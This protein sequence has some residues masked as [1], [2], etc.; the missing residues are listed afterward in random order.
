MNHRN[1]LSRRIASAVFLSSAFCLTSPAMAGDGED[2]A[3]EPVS[4]EA[5]YKSDVVGV[6]DGGVAHGVRWLD[7][8]NVTATLDLD[9][10]AGWN[11]ATVFVNVLNNLGGRPNDL[12][13]SI[14]GINNIE[15]ADTRLK[16]YEAWIEQTL[17]K[18]VS[19][20]AG[21]YDLNSEFYQND[22]S[23]LLISPPFGIGSELSATGPNGPS[24]FP[25]TALAARVNA[26]FGD[27]Y[28]R[29]AVVNA[30]AGTLGDEHGVALFGHDGALLIGELGWS[31]NGKVSV[32]FWRYTKDQPLIDAPDITVG[33]TDHRA[34]GIYFSAE[35]ALYAK[36]GGATVSGFLRG[37]VSDGHTTPFSG[38][39]Q[40][41]VLVEHVFTARPAS[42][43]S[44]GVGS[45]IL[46]SSY[47]DSSAA[48]GAPL[49][50]TETIIEATYKD[51][52]LPG[53]SLQPDVQYVIHPSAD[54]GIR[55]AL[56]IGLRVQFD[57]KLK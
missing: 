34:Q 57:F 29:A 37:G 27:A 48:L 6:V 24:I 44:L 31:G 4:I 52:I 43:F 23:A 14:Q 10:L 35:H 2:E 15:V 32:G 45:A 9:V 51:E 5:S 22:A 21:L 18:A 42:S 53:L 46:S 8:L 55:N 36:E 40:A 17:G 41:G 39:W 50:K 13:G 49:L 56:V 20:R 1:S 25:S 28:V 16:V 3:Q 12:A 11:G 47:R 54:P 7:N 30:K 19:L 33:P 26:S 38:G